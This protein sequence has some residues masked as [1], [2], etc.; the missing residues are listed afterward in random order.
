MSIQSRTEFPQGIIITEDVD[1]SVSEQLTVSLRAMQDDGVGTNATP[2]AKVRFIYDTTGSAVM[3]LTVDGITID[4]ISGTTGD[5]WDI[6]CEMWLNQNT[7]FI[8]IYTIW[9]EDSAAPATPPLSTRTLV[10]LNESQTNGLLDGGFIVK[11]AGTNIDDGD[12]K[13]GYGRNG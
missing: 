13:I 9:D 3:T 12:P 1:G 2:Y 11:V 10:T 7:G 6:T 8:D 5:H 4:A